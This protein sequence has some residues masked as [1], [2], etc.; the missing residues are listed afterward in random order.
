M[1]EL[2]QSRRDQKTIQKV[3]WAIPNRH[4]FVS[5]FSAQSYLRIHPPEASIGLEECGHAVLLGS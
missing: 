5:P 2:V 3:K 4:D 1:S